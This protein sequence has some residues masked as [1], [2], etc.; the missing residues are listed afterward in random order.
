MKKR[1][2]ARSSLDGEGVGQKAE[3][4]DVNVIEI[5]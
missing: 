4:V 1:E 5:D 2:L 3:E